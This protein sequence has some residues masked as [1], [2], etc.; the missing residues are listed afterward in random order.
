MEG[1]AA[2][3][4][5]A[6]VAKASDSCV[7]GFGLCVLTLGEGPY[8]EPGEDGDHCEQSGADPEGAAAGAVLFV[9]AAPV[10]DRFGEDV[11]EQFVAGRFTSGWV[12]LAQDPAAV[13]AAEL[14]EHP[15]DLG[16]GSFRPIGKV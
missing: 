4:E 14:L 9:A 2:D 12:D 8:G 7:C 13:A 16:L 5:L 3:A 1:L 15:G 6:S 10:E 11:V